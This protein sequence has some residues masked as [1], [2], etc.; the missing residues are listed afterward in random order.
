MAKYQY[1]H[2]EAT[3]KKDMFKRQLGSRMFKRDLGNRLVGKRTSDDVTEMNV[4]EFMHLPQVV[5]RSLNRRE[6]RSG[7]PPQI[8]MP[9][10]RITR[11]D[12][13]MADYF[14]RM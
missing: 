2:P 1:E 9:T 13:Q 6:R 12:N 10:I 11:G 8:Q 7:M 3:T 14:G 4:E 5:E